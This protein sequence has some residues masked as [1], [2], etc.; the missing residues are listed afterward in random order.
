MGSNLTRWTSRGRSVM[1]RRAATTSGPM[2]MLGTKR[3]SWQQSACT[4]VRDICTHV[5]SAART[6]QASRV[7]TVYA[8]QARLTMTSTW[9][10]S[11]PASS[12]ALT[13]GVGFAALGCTF[14]LSM[15]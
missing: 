9:I 14:L 5:M 2:V 1:G 3:P 6:A 10:Q 7:A 8:E 11:Q 4:A 13:C 12:T 15:L